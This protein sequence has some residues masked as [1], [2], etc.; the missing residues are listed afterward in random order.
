MVSATRAPFSCG[1][2]GESSTT[3]LRMMPGMATPMAST[4]VPSGMSALISSQMLSARASVGTSMSP[5]DSSMFSGKRRVAPMILWS[6]KKPERMASVMTTPM[7]FA[8]VSSLPSQQ[9]FKLGEAVDAV[10]GGSLV[11]LSQRGIVEHCIDEVVYCPAQR[12]DRL[13]DVDQLCRSLADD[14]DA[15]NGPVFAMED[16]LQAPRGV[17]ANLSARDLAII[18]DADLVGHILL[19]QL[20]FRFADE[21]DF[22]NGVDAVRV[23]AGVRLLGLI[24]K[25]TGDGDASLLHGD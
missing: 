8:M 23:K 12:H 16:Q 18:R 1:R 5:V 19:G 25:G 24:A 9:L 15:E 14:V 6:S 7:V 10:K 22:R 2:L 13:A 4:D 17:A 11:A 20:L 21:G 3:P